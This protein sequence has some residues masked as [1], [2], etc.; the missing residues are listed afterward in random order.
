MTGAQGHGSS[1]HKIKGPFEISDSTR[2]LD[3]ASATG[4]LP[5]CSDLVR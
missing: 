1:L 2:G 3:G 5:Q 4:E